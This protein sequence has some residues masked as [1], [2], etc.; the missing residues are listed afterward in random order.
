MTNHDDIQRLVVGTFLASAKVPTR[1][2]KPNRCLGCGRVTRHIF[3]PATREA[4]HRLYMD[5]RK[6]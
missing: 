6:R 5:G 3:C 4:C 2:A 1:R